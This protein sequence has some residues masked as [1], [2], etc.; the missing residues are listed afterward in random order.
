M[1]AFRPMTLGR[2]TDVRESSVPGG[3]GRPGEEGTGRTRGRGQ[4]LSTSPSPDPGTLST[5]V[6]HR[7]GGCG[8][9]CG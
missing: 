4:T 3:P 2:V 5:G 6:V 1:L 7:C 9:W 8:R